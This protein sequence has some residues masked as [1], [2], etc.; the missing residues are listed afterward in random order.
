VAV[1]RDTNWVLITG[2]DVTEREAMAAEREKLI[3]DLDGHVMAERI[4]NRCLRQISGEFDFERSLRDMLRVIGE[5]AG[6]DCC[7]IHEF[8]ADGVFCNLLCEWIKPGIDLPAIY[9]QP[10]LPREVFADIADMLRQERVI[11]VTDVDKLSATQTRLRDDMRGRGLRGILHVGIFTGD[12]LTGVI[13][14]DSISGVADFGDRSLDILQDAVSLYRLAEERKR[15]LDELERSRELLARAARQAENAATEKSM[16]LATMSHE[17]RTPLTA[18]I[19]FAELLEPGCGDPAVTLESVRAIKLAG[20]TLLDLINDI[21]DLSKLESGKMQ[22]RRT[23]TSVAATVEDIM[24]MFEVKLR[25]KRIYGRIDISGIPPC[26][27]L[28]GLRLRQILLNLVG[29]AVKFT[30]SGGITVRV[31]F[32]GSAIETGILKIEVGDTGIGI[33]ASD[34]ENIFDPFVQSG[35]VEGQGTGL[36]LPICR[37][38]AEQ[39]G[40]RLHAASTPGS[41]SAFTLEL[42]GLCFSSEVVPESEPE[43]AAPEAG[44]RVLAV[45]DQELNRKLLAGLCGRLNLDVRT[46]ASGGEALEMLETFAAEVVLTDLRMPDMAGDELARRIRR[47]PGGSGIKLAMVTADVDAPGSEAAKGFDVVLVKPVTL[48]RLSAFFAET[49]GWEGGGECTSGK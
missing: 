4:I 21:L 20:T 9:R 16:F 45:D 18:V 12:Q 31:R 38:L 43:P 14:I 26:V 37:R 44:I 30:H 19:G 34:L 10:N 23:P 28:D 47:R 25:E 17:L 15:R 22:L 5:A 39:M 33:A 1:G 27:F 29:N 2:L 42:P 41:G 11:R 3:R 46:A 35:A 24:T 8:T 36:G 49:R 40:G 13:G 7:H 32:D 48:A 6:A